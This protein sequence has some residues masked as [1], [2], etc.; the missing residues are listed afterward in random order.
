MTSRCTQYLPHKLIWRAVFHHM[1]CGTW[2]N[3]SR[4]GGIY[5]PNCRM[6]S[7]LRVFRTNRIASGSFN[8]SQEIS[9][10]ALSPSV[11][12]Q[13]PHLNL[14]NFPSMPST[15]TLV[16]QFTTSWR[17]TRWEC[18]THGSYVYPSIC[19]FIPFDFSTARVTHN[20]PTRRMILRR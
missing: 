3:P 19:L 2:R 18:C 4:P 6:P 7:G 13:T 8:L 16:H 1:Y 10:Q 11:R 17:Q 12:T 5:L 9:A 20:F 14:L 15:K